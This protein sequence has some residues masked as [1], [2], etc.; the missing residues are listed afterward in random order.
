M[1]AL[2]ARASKLAG[3]ALEDW[4]PNVKTSAGG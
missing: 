3:A 1:A 2:R 4:K